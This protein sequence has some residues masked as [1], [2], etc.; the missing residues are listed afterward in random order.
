[1][2]RHLSRLTLRADQT[3]MR[4]VSRGTYR[5]ARPCGQERCVG[6][7]RAPTPDEPFG[8]G[9]LR[10]SVSSVHP[11]RARARR[12]GPLPV[13]Q[14]P[15][16]VLAGRPRPPGEGFSRAQSILTQFATTLRI[17]LLVHPA[18]GPAEACPAVADGR[19]D[20][21]RVAHV[22]Q[23]R[24][25][26]ERHRPTLVATSAQPRSWLPIGLAGEEPASDHHDTPEDLALP[27]RRTRTETQPV[28]GPLYGV[29]LPS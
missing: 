20:A 26:N 9:A 13:L 10:T 25:K 3:S 19:G 5:S 15:R 8:A 18:T 22:G 24:P 14:V 16:A 6:R 28:K 1:V 12:A 17:S 2:K 4:L 21:H 27:S 7:S 23:T 11:P 29:L